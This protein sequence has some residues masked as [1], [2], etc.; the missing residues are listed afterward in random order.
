MEPGNRRLAQAF[1][2]LMWGVFLLVTTVS[3]TTGN[4]TRE[5]DHILSLSAMA[6]LSIWAYFVGFYSREL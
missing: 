1:S 4:L 2:L 5:N 3:L 6:L